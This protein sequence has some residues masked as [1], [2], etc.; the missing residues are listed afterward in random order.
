MK[1]KKYPLGLFIIVVGL[2]IAFISAFLLAY[3]NKVYPRTQLNNGIDLSGLS[4]QQVQALIEK[5]SRQ[6]GRSV[7]TL[8]S[9]NQ[10]W[11]ISAEE[12]DLDF[13]SQQSAQKAFALS[14]QSL[15]QK[16][17]VV[18]EIKFDQS[19]LSEKVATIAAQIYQPGIP[20]EI[21]LDGDKNVQINLGKI[22]KTLDQDRLKEKIIARFLSFSDQDI[23]LPVINDRQLPD[24][25]QVNQARDRAQKLV[26][27]TIALIGPNS[28]FVID[29]Q[30]LVSFVD[31]ENG[32]DETKVNQYLKT[33]A[34]S[35]DQ[36]AENALFKF[37]D[38]RVTSFKEDKNGF[39]L[40]QDGTRKNLLMTLQE[41]EKNQTGSLVLE[42][43][44]KVIR[45]T[46]T[47][48]D[49]NQL[50]IT[51]LLGT[52]ESSFPHSIPAR[53]HNLSLASGKIDGLLIGPGET[54][55]LNQAL[56]DISKATNYQDAYIIQDGRTVLGAGGGVCQVSTT[57]F[58]AVLNSGL[59][60]LERHPHAYRVSY[61]ETNSKVGFDA[62]VFSPSADFMFQNDTESQILI[63]REIDLDRQYLAFRLY[64]QPDGRKVE[65]SNIKLWNVSA[66]PPALYID[67]PTLP[68]GVVKQ[69]DWSAPGGKASFDWKVSREDQ[70]LQEKTFFSNYQPWKAIFLRG[71]GN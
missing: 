27:K 37:E 5:E 30:Q 36:E 64:G 55:S 47:T 26:G 22:E 12:I 38:N 43:P 67:D 69:I 24:E 45:P 13:Q 51:G 6:D 11:S 33:L 44:V 7:V 31:F 4:Q 18:P 3:Q 20:D 21:S 8:T 9:Q 34:E 65:I 50:G 53:I 16:T 59:P 68:T 28:S 63:Q 32:W 14:R 66:P 56:G 49:S 46:I 52:G 40:D 29:D 1:Q 35:I 19:K 54:F 15:T 70:V 17:T 23:S 61:Y 42:L 48:A 2:P 71:T 58:R 62:S 57:L 41:M 39:L 10:K 25:N 60:I